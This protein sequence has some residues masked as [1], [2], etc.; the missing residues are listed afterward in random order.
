MMHARRRITSQV[1]NI[2]K[3]MARVSHPFKIIKSEALRKVS[4]YP[5]H[6]PMPASRH[7]AHDGHIP[8]DK[9]FLFLTLLH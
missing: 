5:P 1:V 2:Y 6:P 3:R 4:N 7:S 9:Q 8:A